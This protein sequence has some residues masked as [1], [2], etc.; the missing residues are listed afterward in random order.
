M[1]LNNVKF[2][3]LISCNTGHQDAK[4]TN[5]AAAIGTRITG[6]VVASDGTVCAE[7]MNYNG[8][9]IL[10]A[11]SMMDNTWKKYVANRSRAEYWVLCKRIRTTSSVNWYSWGVTT[12]SIFSIADYLETNGYISFK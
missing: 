9:T 1:D 5:I 10:G 11:L 2:V 4:T 7:Y 8:K 6:M 12:V 3:W